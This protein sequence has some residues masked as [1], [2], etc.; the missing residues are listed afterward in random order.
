MANTYYISAAGSNAASGLTEAEAWANFA[1]L[2]ERE[3]AP[4]EQVLL[5]RGDCWDQQLTV[6]GG[7]TPGAPVVIG[8]Y[9]EGA[10]PR[11][12]RSGDIA[13]R[14][15]R[16]E[17]AHHLILEDLEVCQAGA[18]IVLFYRHSYC[19]EDVTIRRVEAHDFF[20]IYRASGESSRNP[21][22]QSYRAPD[23][24]GFSLGICVTGEDSTPYNDA[25]VLTGFTVQDCHIYNTGAGIGLDWC[26]HR[27]SDGTVTGCNKFGNV[28]FERLRLHDN[29][30]PDVSVTSMF[31][32]CVTGAVVRD[33]VIDAGAGGAPWGTAAIHLQL[34]RD[35]LLENVTVSRIPHT[36][37]S[38]E[39]GIDFETDVENCTIRGCTFE[40]NA[41][42]GIEFLANFEMSPFAASRNVVI[43][44]C[45]FRNNNWA[46]LYEEPGQI[47]VKLWQH[48]N[49]PTGVV[50]GCR[51]ENPEGVHFVGGDGIRSCFREEGNQPLTL[52]A[53]GQERKCAV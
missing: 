14:C 35:V 47:L 9:G 2:A 4:G 25:R 41:G 46:R 13:E 5:R 16:L 34:A 1:P 21:A 28:L 22:W 38:D 40:D 26:D 51:Y 3:L 7:G 8:A 31:L 52:A 49:C 20:G 39:C 10:L 42:A 50:R 45:L 37:V 12:C 36:G 11:I 44:D 43:E 6:R 29:T 23:R 30:V 18:G 17:N 27:N 48:D 53:D 24:V 32:Q 33:T 19:N 15:V